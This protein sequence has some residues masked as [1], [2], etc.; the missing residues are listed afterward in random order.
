MFTCCYSFHLPFVVLWKNPTQQICWLYYMWNL[1]LLLN[2]IK[3]GY[4]EGLKSLF[5]KW[6]L[7]FFPPLPP[8]PSDNLILSCFT[9]LLLYNFL[10]FQMECLTK[11]VS[12][13]LHCNVN[14]K[15]TE[16]TGRYFLWLFHAHTKRL[17]K[18][19]PLEWLKRIKKSVPDLVENFFQTLQV[20]FFVVFFLLSLSIARSH[21]HVHPCLSVHYW[22]PD[23]CA[24]ISMCPSAGC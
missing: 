12:F 3:C 16:L 19:V 1:L 7:F 22:S 2:C 11:P 10:I 8:P 14:S 23:W 15:V 17:L 21:K 4:T 18:V 20:E 24:T 5:S 6:K 13:L 9:S